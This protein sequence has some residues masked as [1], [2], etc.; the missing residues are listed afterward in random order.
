MSD[1][2]IK[3]YA[4]LPVIAKRQDTDTVLIVDEDGALKRT[5]DVGSGGGG[6]E[7][8]PNVIYY[9]MEDYD[10]QLGWPATF[11]PPTWTLDDY[12]Y[13]LTSEDAINKTNGQSI[14]ALLADPDR[15]GGLDVQ[16]I[17]LWFDEEAETPHWVISDSWKDFRMDFIMGEG[18]IDLGYMNSYEPPL[19]GPLVVAYNWVINSEKDN[20]QAPLLMTDADFTT[21][22]SI[23]PDNPENQLDPGN[24]NDGE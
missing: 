9:R 7:A 11:I 23:R 5:T 20:P 2:N 6:G 10:N 17:E 14:G 8:K 15:L 21:F 16:V 12:K 4:D 19:T 24:G 3:R 18:G 22:Q 13:Y 1:L